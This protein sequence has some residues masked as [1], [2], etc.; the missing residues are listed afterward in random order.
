MS[1]QLDAVTRRFAGKM[2]VD[3][4]SLDIPAGTFFV[5]VGPSGCGK[6]TLLRLIAGLE[7]PDSG[8]IALNGKTVAGPGVHVGPEDRGVGVV[9]QSYALWPHMTVAGNVAF[10]LETAG[11]GRKAARQA[12]AGHLDTVALGPH[13]L[14]KPAE[15][16]GGQ[17]QRVAL[18]RCLAQGAQTVLMDEPLANLDPHLRASMEEELAAF[19]RRSQ[20]TTLYITHD[21]HEAMAL[22]GQIAVM[23]DGCILQ[24]GPPEAV[25]ARPVCERVAGF[26]GKGVVVPAAVVAVT[27][28]KAQ[29]RLGTVLFDA[30]CP[31]ATTPGPARLLLR[32]EQ[33]AV[34][35]GG[36][37]A[38]IAR[39]TFRGNH[40]DAVA[41]LADLAGSIPISLQNKPNVGDRLDL[42][43]RG[44]WVLPQA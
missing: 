23:W 29:V 44:G 26:I 27:G 11:M 41:E 7:K 16:S 4:V 6:S 35:A 22:A 42:E 10:P 30:D 36:L 1:I 19:H 17:R 24:S 14:R 20:A 38:R 8:Q 2:A 12:A 34:G 18:A 5:V 21:Q 3:G 33:V 25:Y 37:A 28:T 40:W 39:V 13:A 15:L 32:P 43:I 9:F 31:V